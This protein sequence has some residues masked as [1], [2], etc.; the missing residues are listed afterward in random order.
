MRRL[1]ILL[2]QGSYPAGDNGAL[3][4]EW[5]PGSAHPLACDRE[6][7]AVKRQRC[8]SVDGDYIRVPWCVQ[9]RL[10]QRFNSIISTLCT[11]AHPGAPICSQT[12]WL[13]NAAVS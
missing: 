3:R 12:T 5:R 9:E 4:A 1:A 13:S 10:C 7:G 6:R 2:P 11:R 8:S